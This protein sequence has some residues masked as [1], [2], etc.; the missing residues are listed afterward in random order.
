PF[1]LTLCALDPAS[2]DQTA[3]EED[4]PDAAHARRVNIED[5]II[6]RL[7]TLLMEELRAESPSG[8]LCADSPAHALAVGIRHVENGYPDR[9]LCSRICALRLPAL[10]RVLNR[11]EESFRTELAL[12]SLGEETGYSR[13]HFFKMF[14]KAMGITPHHYGLKR[15]V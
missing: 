3:L 13:G 15:R 6:Q 8:R 4:L 10:R 5:P 12:A 9:K 2:I 11:I 14:R 7:V 1:E